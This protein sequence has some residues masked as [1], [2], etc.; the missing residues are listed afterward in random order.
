MLTEQ[1]KMHWK[2]KPLRFHFLQDLTPVTLLSASTFLFNLFATTF[3]HNE[4]DFIFIAILKCV[5]ARVQK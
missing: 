3:L 4:N 5:Y 2:I 1:S